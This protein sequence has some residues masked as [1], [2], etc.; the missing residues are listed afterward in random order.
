[1]LFRFFTILLLLSLLVHDSAIAQLKTENVVLVTLDGMRWQELFQGADRD[2][3]NC[4]KYVKDPKSIKDRFW[5][6]NPVV[7]REKLFPFIWSTIAS[8]GQIYGNRTLGN[9]VN[10]ANRYWFSYPGYNEL[11]TG[12][13]DRRIN[14]NARRNN[15]NQ[16]ILEFV[17]QQKEYKN[18]VA[19]FASWDVFHYIIN[20]QRSGIHINAGNDTAKA[21]RL[22]ARELYLNHLQASSPSPWGST[23][24]DEFTHQYAREYF[25]RDNPRLLLIAYGETDEYAH[26]GNYSSYLKSANKTDSYIKEIWEWIQS[27]EQYRNKTTMII[28]TDHG[29]GNGKHTWRGHGKGKKGSNSTWFMVIGPDTSPLGEMKEKAHYYNNQLAQTIAAFLNISYPHAGRESEP[30][31]TAF[32]K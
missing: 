31:A 29:R 19:A 17:N 1:M 14:S 10:V 20:Q 28:T 13:P 12:Y 21:Q 9:K 5:D 30:I 26:Q 11:L 7:S 25:K 16:T 2:I 27:S 24:F 22:S 6:N 3:I 18:K 32:E 8:Q 4:K 23:R 15:P